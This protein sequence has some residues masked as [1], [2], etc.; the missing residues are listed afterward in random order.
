MQDSPKQIRLILTLDKSL[1]L[2]ELSKLTCSM[3]KI[4]DIDVSRLKNKKLAAA[5]VESFIILTDRF[6]P[7]DFTKC[8]LDKKTQNIQGWIRQAKRLC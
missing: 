1:D 2:D 7:T 3:A 4:I 6:V 8:N 5:N